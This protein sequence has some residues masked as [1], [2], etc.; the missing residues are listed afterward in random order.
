M[1]LM[2]LTIGIYVEYITSAAPIY[3]QVT[4]LYYGQ[5]DIRGAT[6]RHAVVK[7]SN[8]KEER[9]ASTIPRA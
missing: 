3:S 4:A 6:E 2:L 1:C 7:I 9:T 5:F 8:A